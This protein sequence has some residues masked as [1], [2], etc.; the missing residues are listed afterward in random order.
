MKK[1]IDFFSLIRWLNLLILLFTQLLAAWCLSDYQH[2]S[3]FISTRFLMLLSGTLLIAAAGYILNDYIDVK[4]DLV[5][6][7]RKVVVGKSISRR[8][9]MIWHF[10][11]NAAALLMGLLLSW[12]IALLFSA[13]ILLLWIYSSRLKK[14]FFIGNLTVAALTGISLLM[15]PLFD[16]NISMNYIL[17]YAGFAFLI[18][19]VREIIKDIE[20]MK[21]D[22][23]Y[24][25]R[26]LP[27]E[28]GIRP[29]KLV[30]SFIMSTLMLVLLFYTL[31]HAQRMGWFYLAYGMLAVVVPMNLFLFRLKKADKKRDFSL[32]SSYCKVIMLTGI[33][34]MLF[35]KI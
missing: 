26:T 34:S 13:A 16:N 1:I 5:N 29:A 18:T 8:W 17:A 31:F 22:A 4:L 9:A 12:R 20:D 19:L 24:A 2:I 25:A 15:L 27:I 3:H 35:F 21:G 14:R 6:K 32:L 11:F 7:P 10:V 33:L 28:M 23:K 30:V